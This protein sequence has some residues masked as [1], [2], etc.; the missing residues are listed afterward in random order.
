[1]KDR[2]AGSVRVET[3]AAVGAFGASISMSNIKNCYRSAN[4]TKCVK[5]FI[6]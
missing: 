4:C 3:G 5:F 6:Y 1:M 2:K